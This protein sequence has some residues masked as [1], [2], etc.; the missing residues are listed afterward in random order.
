MGAGGIL[1]RRVPG[2]LSRSF[3]SRVSFPRFCLAVRSLCKVFSVLPGLL[4]KVSDVA[5]RCP[6]PRGGRASLSCVS[7]IFRLRG[8]RHTW[9]RP[10]KQRRKR[11]FSCS[12]ANMPNPQDQDHSDLP[13]TLICDALLS[14]QRSCTLS[15]FVSDTPRESAPLRFHGAAACDCA[16]GARHNS[17]RASAS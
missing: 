6:R 14:C 5:G 9:T 8:S 11:P 15:R 3:A 12:R 17:V 4:F 1:G 13:T 10:T 16:V 7:M 2:T